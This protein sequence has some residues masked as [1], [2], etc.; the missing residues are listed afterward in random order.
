MTTEAEPLTGELFARLACQQDTLTF[1]AAYDSH[2][3]ALTDPRWV[4]WLVTTAGPT[5]TVLVVELARQFETNDQWQVSPKLLAALLGVGRSRLSVAIAQAIRY[6]ILFP[7]PSGALALDLR[8]TP[9]REPL[10]WP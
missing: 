3:V 9:P 2:G 10:N 4:R 8:T 6:R 5:A 1:L 7:H